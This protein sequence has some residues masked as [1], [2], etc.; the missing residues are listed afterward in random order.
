MS[1]RLQKFLLRPAIFSSWQ[2]PPCL[3]YLP[4]S[5][6]SELYFITLLPLRNAIRG[7]IIAGEINSA[8]FFES[9]LPTARLKPKSR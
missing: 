7:G 2:S 9:L 4:E 8:G 5:R 6:H 1:A 3:S